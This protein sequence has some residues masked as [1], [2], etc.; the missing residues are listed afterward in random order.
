[1]QTVLSN[2]IAQLRQLKGAP[3]SVVLALMFA[4]SPVGVDWLCRVTGYTDKPI[5]QALKY[6][7]DLQIATSTNRYQSWQLAKGYQLPLMPPVPNEL[8]DQ[9]NRNNSDSPATTTSINQ[10]DLN[11]LK[12]LSSSCS[13]KPNRKN[14]DSPIQPEQLPE[15]QAQIRYFLISNGVG[16]PM[17]TRI[18]ISD[19][20]DL[21]YVKCHILGGRQENLPL[22]LIIHKMKS[23]DFAPKVNPE[24]GH[25]FDCLCSSCRPY[26]YAD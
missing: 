8:S 5:S 9:G 22:R 18:A 14:S 19:G 26:I 13:N 24:T 21:N 6:L 7:E 10:K 2:P 17:A 4:G 12:K 11:N 25:K 15:D 1:M 23:G 16:D 3:L 20:V